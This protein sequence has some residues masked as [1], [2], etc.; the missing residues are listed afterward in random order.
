MISTSLLLALASAVAHNWHLQTI[1]TFFSQFVHYLK[2][3]NPVCRPH[4]YPQYPFF[5]IYQLLEIAWVD[6]GFYL[7]VTG[8]G[9]AVVPSIVKMSAKWL[10]N[11]VSYITAYNRFATNS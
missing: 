3:A 5:M 4:K 8:H 7:D 11:S 1:G 9:H 10:T 6:S 2:M